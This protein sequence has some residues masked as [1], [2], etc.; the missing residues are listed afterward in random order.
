MALRVSIVSEHA[1]R[2]GDLASRVFGV[3][4]GTIGRALENEWPLPDPE[5][6][7]SAK[8]ARIEFRAGRYYLVDM[9]SNGTYVNG[10]QVPLGRFH[11]YAMRD[12]DYFRIGEYELLVSIDES[13]DF[14]PDASAIVAYDGASA[15]SAVRKSTADDIGAD[16]DLSALLEPSDR[17]DPGPGPIARDAYGRPIDRE[18][19]PAPAEEE[20]AEAVP[21]HMMT[22]PLSVERAAAPTP[23]VA[24]PPLHDG[25]CDPGVAT[26]CRGAGLDP[27]ALNPAARAAALHLAGQLL[28]EAVL[29]LIDLGQG[30]GELRSRLRI[31]PPPA[32]E[33]GPGVK[34]GPG[35]DETLL[36]LLTTLSQRAGAVES[37][38]E[39][40]RE[41]KAE[42]GATLGAMHAALEEFLARFDPKDLEERFERGGKRGV[43]ATQNKAKYWDMYTDL[44]AGLSQRADGGLPLWFAE[45]FAKAYT[46]KLRS[47][48]PPRRG[49]FGTDAPPQA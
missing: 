36:R 13:N 6:Y 1:T 41:L 44:Y 37:L 48:A 18:V 45:A 34:F 21:W 32:E 23:R 28:R 49:T 2:L 14:P 33:A 47:L 26:F 5:R 9:S 38:R 24:P 15:S 40:F 27:R 10:A 20:P 30:R 42:G 43:F 29:G 25:E 17:L 8:H 4:G 12:G 7:L 3:H 35:V 39:K 19:P 31:A 11:E 46:D 22:R 16:L